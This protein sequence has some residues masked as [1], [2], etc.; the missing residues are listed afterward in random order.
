MLL[1]KTTIFSIYTYNDIAEK[2]GGVTYYA[3]PP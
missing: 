2:T 1:E 3:P